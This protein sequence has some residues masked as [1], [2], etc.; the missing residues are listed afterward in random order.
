MGKAKVLVT[1]AGENNLSVVIEKLEKL[2][3]KSGPF[4]C[5]ILLGNLASKLDTIDIT[6]KL[7]PI[8]VPGSEDL[9]REGLVTLKNGIY[10]SKSGLKIGYFT[11]NDEKEQSKFKEP[12]DV[13]ITNDCSVAIGG[14]HLKIPGN[15][16]VDEVVKLSHPKYHFTYADSN[17]FAELEPFVWQDD[18]KVTR[19][20]NL[21]AYGSKNKWAYAFNIDTDVNLPLPNELMR[22]PYVSNQVT[23]KHPRENSLLDKETQVKKP[24]GEVKKVLP[25]A[26]HFCFTNPDIEDHMVISI[27]SKSYVTTAKGPLSIPRGDM[28]FSGHCLIIPIEHVPKLNMDDKDFFQNELRKELLHYENSIAEMNYKK[29]DM[30]TV[31]FE[32]HSDNMV[33]FHK[34]VVPIP[35]YLTM[36]FLGAL[37]RQV[38]IN[39]EKF[40]RNRNIEF[41]FFESPEDSKYRE[42]INDYKSNYMMFS[43]HETPDVPP[44]IY[45]G[46]FDANDRIDLQ[47]G[48]RTLAFLLHLPNRVN[49]RSPTCLQSKEQ[50]EMEVSKF[51]KAYRDY[52]IT[53]ATE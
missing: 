11:G 45:F 15:N 12:I 49:W 37:D 7:P 8:F 38:H 28:D 39:N 43:I 44:K 4:D 27:A 51:Q 29:F 22:N 47:F 16:V 36:K 46:K 41:E 17:N 9:S 18:Q 42:I 48:R 32:I 30:S 35:K 25:V 20:I 10:K 33:H 23:R 5:A 31:V 50:E 3:A 6:A 14:E 40:G 24:T 52:D 26:C 13:L 19:F 34:Q 1:H 53:G 21:A 2:N